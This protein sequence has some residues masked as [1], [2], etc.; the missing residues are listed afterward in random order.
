MVR[1]PLGEEWGVGA[2][3]AATSGTASRGQVTAAGRSAWTS[4]SATPLTS[5]D[6]G[7][8]RPRFLCPPPRRWAVPREGHCSTEAAVCWGAAHWARV[9]PGQLRPGLSRG[10]ASGGPRAW[11][12]AS[13]GRGRAHVPL[14]T[15]ARAH[16]GMHTHVHTQAHVHRHAHTHVHT[17]MHIGGQVASSMSW[18]LSRWVWDLGV[19]Q[20]RKWGG[21]TQWAC[22]VPV[23]SVAP[24]PATAAPRGTSISSHSSAPQGGH[25]TH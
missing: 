11:C 23:A 21:C 22:R 3:L 19:S 9:R 6:A 13:T 20:R 15:G 8:S 24:P 17:H 25:G 7:A 1:L 5:T 4:V 10:V 2:G 14:V 12:E 16:T 18:H